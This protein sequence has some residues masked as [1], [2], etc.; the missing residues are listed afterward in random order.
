MLS[1]GSYI[2]KRM[3]M[4]ILEIQEPHDQKREEETQDIAIGIDLG[5][6]NSLVAF[7]TNGMARV[8]PDDDGVYILPS[9]VNY[10]QG[11]CIVGLQALENNGYVRSVKSIL[12]KDHDYIRDNFKYPHIFDQNGIAKIQ[13]GDE[14]KTGI[15]LSAEILIC[16]KNRAENFLN[17]KVEYAI[18]TVPAYFN[19]H[20]R[21]AVKEAA[22]LSG[23]KVLRLINE[24]TAAA[25][26][27]GLDKNISGKFLV[28]DLGGG[29]FDISLLEKKDNVFKV[30]ATCGDTNFGGDTLDDL[31]MQYCLN[32]IQRH[33]TQ[34]S[35]LDY[36]KH[37]FLL[38]VKKAK[39]ELSQ[40][41]G[42]SS[43]GVELNFK[44]TKCHL[45]LESFNN[46]IHDKIQ[47]SVDMVKDVL[48]EAGSSPS[49]I[50]GIVMVGGSTRIPYI[51]DLL[52][53]QLGIDLYTNLNPD[54]IVALG[55]ALQADNLINGGSRGLLLDITPLS[56]GLEVMGGLVDKVIQR[57]TRIPV[58][59]TKEFTNYVDNQAAISFH[60]L[61]GEREK[62]EDC[63]SLGKF[64]LKDIHQ[65]QAGTARIE[66]T[67]A[68]DADGILVVSARDNNSGSKYDIEI[69]SLDDLSVQNIEQMLI[70]SLEH[71]QEDMENKLIIEKQ[72]SLKHDIE[73]IKKALVQYGDKVTPP[74]YKQLQAIVDKAEKVISNA[75]L[76]DLTSMSNELDQSVSWFVE[77]AVHSDIV[78]GLQGMKVDELAVQVQAGHQHGKSDKESSNQ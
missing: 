25:F 7:A 21:I 70:D 76:N 22:R 45:S 51:Q 75:Q 34:F 64:E 42:D 65:C 28:Y 33:D 57:N 13:V 27:Y 24:P 53:Q 5:T 68:I 15:E 77:M 10:L 67:F 74:Q 48:R 47:Y 32:E 66:V 23:L 18:I 19:D 55:A 43:S 69:N 62:V 16:L 11:K 44:N 39:E 35:L 30:L 58:S 71:G 26:A 20:Q 49:Q 56:L 6:T 78:D 59:V 61:Q 40:S 2:N 17:K 50:T 4:E 36:E 46:I 60:I 31:C 12:G 41:D 54:E 63:R 8:I 37:E 9:I 3:D 1:L 38:S 52:V 14:Q 72:E 73:Y 29:T